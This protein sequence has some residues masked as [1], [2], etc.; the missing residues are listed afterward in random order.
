MQPDD[1]VFD[2]APHEVRSYSLTIRP[3]QD[4]P[5][6][7]YPFEITCLPEGPVGEYVAA[8]GTIVIR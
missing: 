6:G 3:P 1:V 4:M 5:E 8:G 7:R 2:L